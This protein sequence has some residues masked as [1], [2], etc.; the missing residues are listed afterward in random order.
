MLAIMR[1]AEQIFRSVLAIALAA[2]AFDCSA[3]TTP[4]QAMQCCKSM[5]CSSHGHHGQDCCKDMPTIHGPFVQLSSQHGL[6]VSPV[7][8]AVAPPSDEC[9]G[10]DFSAQTFAAPCH[11]P[12]IFS[13][14]ASRPLRI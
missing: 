5:H 3:A 8:F 4:E 12:P 10:L 14:P 2:Y 6:S 11:A 13:P 1:L 7:V 9:L